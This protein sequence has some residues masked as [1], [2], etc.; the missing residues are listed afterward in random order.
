M[1][2][3]SKNSCAHLRT[4]VQNYIALVIVLAGALVG[5][6]FVDVVQL[7][8]GA[9]FSSKAVH[10]ATIIPYD[11]RTWVA[12]TEPIVPLTIIA[13]AACT[14]CKLDALV[15]WL[16]YTIPTVDVHIVDAGSAAGNALMTQYDLTQVPSVLFGAPITQTRFYANTQ[17]LFLP[18]ST[19]AYLFDIAA[20]SLVPVRYVRAPHIPDAI[21]AGAKS[22]QTTVTLVGHF[23]CA[24]CADAH[25]A[26]AAALTQR[27]DAIAYTFIPVAAGAND[28]R[29]DR[30]AEAAYCAAAQDAFVAYARELFRTRRVWQ[31]TTT[32][33]V[34]VR[35]AR[36]ARIPDV[37]AFQR[38]LTDGTYRETLA[39]ARANIARLG[40]HDTPLMFV[41][42]AQAKDVRAL[43]AAL[44]GTAG[45]AA[46]R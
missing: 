31:R 25:A 20:L 11:G 46:A 14:D 44:A 32:D 16:Q 27:P 17:Q 13:D 7:V 6:M 9:G 4:R 10:S 42:D 45:A 35:A 39:R 5:S 3:M 21:H 12:Y 33:A 34:F 28:A 19:G 18:Q 23:A 43:R 1:K 36:T 8:R 38:C 15:A 41:N 24:Q 2:R 26:I 30:A 40:T 22:A 37:P 29:G